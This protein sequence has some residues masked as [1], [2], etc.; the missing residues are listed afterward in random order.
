[1]DWDHVALT[2]QLFHVITLMAV[3]TAHVRLATILLTECAKVTCNLLSCSHYPHSHSQ[4][5]FCMAPCGLPSCNEPLIRL[6]ISV[7]YT[8]F[9]C[10]LISL[11]TSFL[12]SCDF[13]Y[14]V[15]HLSFSLRIGTIHFPTKG[16]KRQIWYLLFEF[17]LCFCS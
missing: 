16:R 1:M 13:T 7:L 8:S 9:A 10:L 4:V 12:Y 17:I 15:P 3:T 6:L 2:S 14:L 5:A 11:L